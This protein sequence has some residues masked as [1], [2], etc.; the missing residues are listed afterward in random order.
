MHTVVSCKKM[1]AGLQKGAVEI[2]GM[3]VEMFDDVMSMP[4]VG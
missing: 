2:A 1:C 4:R 3:L